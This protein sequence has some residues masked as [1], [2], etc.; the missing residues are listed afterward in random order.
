MEATMPPEVTVVAEPGIGFVNDV[1]NG[2]FV[3]LA[4]LTVTGFARVRFVPIFAIVIPTEE[5]P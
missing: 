1:N 3:M 2:A 4:T 5:K